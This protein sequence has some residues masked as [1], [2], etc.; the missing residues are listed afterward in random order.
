MAA[1]GVSSVGSSDPDPS[2]DALRIIGVV[3]F[4]LERRGRGEGGKGDG[5]GADAEALIGRASRILGN[6]SGTEESGVTL[7]SPLP[8]IRN[9]WENSSPFPSVLPRLFLSV[10]PRNQP[11]KEEDSRL[12]RYKRRRFLETRSLSFPTDSR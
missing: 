6:I 9:E 7:T 2:G 3:S 5:L 12:D 11:F 8:A 10:Q 1:A 4:I